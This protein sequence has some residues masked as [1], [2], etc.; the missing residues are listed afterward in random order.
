MK[1]IFLLAAAFTVVISSSSAVAA[2]SSGTALI[3]GDGTQ[4]HVNNLSEEGS[5]IAEFLR[6][7]L[8]SDNVDNLIFYIHG[9]GKEPGKS[10]QK[11]IPYIEEE[12]SSSVLMF[13][14]YP[15]YKG[16][17]GY[18]KKEAE[19]A[20]PALAKAIEY[21]WEYKKTN[22][23]KFNGIKVTFLVH[24][25]G[26]IVFEK[27]MKGYQEGTLSADL[28]DTIILSSPDTDADTHHAWVSKIDFSENIYITVNDQDKMLGVSAK[29]QLKKR[30]G[31]IGGDKAVTIFD[32]PITLAPN[33]VYVDFSETGVNHRYFIKSGQKNN[34]WINEFYDEVMNGNS[35]NMEQ[36]SGVKEVR[37]LGNN[38]KFYV[39]KAE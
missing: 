2:S 12:Y 16:G 39:I 29:K 3:T 25:M 33:A 6:F 17:I 13:H 20:A 11:V 21:F 32:S 7:S 8:D 26:N 22:G 34:H 4:Y 36:F 15:S 19:S 35:V 38:N 9:R 37:E 28:F 10:L 18:P 1:T 14:W 24:S 23:D 5:E 31:Q 27:F 30:L